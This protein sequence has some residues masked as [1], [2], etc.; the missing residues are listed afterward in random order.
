MSSGNP[1][2]TKGF[3]VGGGNYLTESGNRIGKKEFISLC[4]EKCSCDMSCL[5][6]VNR[7]EIDLKSFLDKKDCSRY[8]D[9]SGCCTLKLITMWGN[10]TLEQ[11]GMLFGLTRERVRQIEEKAL[12]RLQL[13]LGHKKEQLLECSESLQKNRWN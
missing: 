2:V 10:M 7:L 11:I 13:R 9:H 6:K 3:F 5:S 4:K 8:I 12:S 1:G